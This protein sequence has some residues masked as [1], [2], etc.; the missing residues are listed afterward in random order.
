MV[1]A[2]LVSKRLLS[3]LSTYPKAPRMAFTCGMFLALVAAYVGAFQNGIYTTTCHSMKLARTNYINMLHTSS[4][5]SFHYSK[6]HGTF[7]QA[8]NIPSSLEYRNP[9]EFHENAERRFSFSLQAVLS[10]RETIDV[11]KETVLLSEIVG[12]YVKDVQ[13][14]GKDNW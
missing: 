9:S 13:P 14:K 6:S 4:Y 5:Q 2:L 1:L 12:H 3:I 11:I 7:R 10:L 8:K